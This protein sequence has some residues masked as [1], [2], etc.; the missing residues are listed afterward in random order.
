M[1]NKEKLIAF[2]ALVID[3]EQVDAVKSIAREKGAVLSEKEE[4]VKVKDISEN[5]EY[6]GIQFEGVCSEKNLVT[7]Q[8]ELSDNTFL[9]PYELV[10]SPAH[11]AYPTTDIELEPGTETLLTMHNIEHNP[12]DQQRN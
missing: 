2:S 3:F 9:D 4:I 12:L 1:K 6:H 5:K 11:K 8:K 10:D 7:L